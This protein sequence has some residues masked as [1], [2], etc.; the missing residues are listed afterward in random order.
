MYGWPWIP[1]FC[2]SWGD[3]LIIFKSDEV[4]SENIYRNASLVTN[5]GIHDDPYIILYALNGIL[6]SYT[7]K[8][9]M[10][11]PSSFRL[12]FIH[13]YQYELTCNY[14]NEDLQ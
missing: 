7:Q 9:Q 1:I 10:H 13:S 12:Y 6:R 2:H 4:M 14:S 5:N 8:H 3:S 11:T